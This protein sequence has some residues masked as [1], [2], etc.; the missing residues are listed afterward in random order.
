MKIDERLMNYY[1]SFFTSKCYYL[2]D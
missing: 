1:Y 2:W